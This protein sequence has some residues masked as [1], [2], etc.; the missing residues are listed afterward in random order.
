MEARF[1]TGSVNGVFRMQE[2]ISISQ[3]QEEI[4]T[5]NS[6]NLPQQSARRATNI[7]L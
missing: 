2:G 3:M 6:G 5:E 4:A 1:D 7:F